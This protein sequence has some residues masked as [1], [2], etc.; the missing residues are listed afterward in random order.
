MKLKYIKLFE[1]FNKNK[2]SSS[3]YVVLV[4]DKLENPVGKLSGFSEK[5]ISVF[6]ESGRHNFYE[7]DVFKSFLSQSNLSIDSIGS[8]VIVREIETE[9]GE[10]VFE[11]TPYQ[12]KS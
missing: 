9:T 2:M 1:N 10:S 4:F 7:T 11:P 3:H 12:F 6:S 8:L 5:E